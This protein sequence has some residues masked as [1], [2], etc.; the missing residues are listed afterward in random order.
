M[1]SHGAFL[2]GFMALLTGQHKVMDLDSNL[3]SRNNSISILDFV[4]GYNDKHKK[5][6][7]DVK[8]KA[9][10]VQLIEDVETIVK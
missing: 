6:F 10:N 7:V 5:S 4:N 2:E 9:F 3:Q 1:I 8:L